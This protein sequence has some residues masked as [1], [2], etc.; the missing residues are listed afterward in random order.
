[1]KAQLLIFYV[2]L[3]ALFRGI[4]H[5]VFAFSVRRGG[6]QLEQAADDLQARVEA[7]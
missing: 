6:K 1:M 4:G 3:A 7:L 5:I 2:G